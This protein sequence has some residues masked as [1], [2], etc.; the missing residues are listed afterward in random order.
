MLIFL[1]ISLTFSI[2]VAGFFVSKS[3]FL[4]SRVRDLEDS[5]DILKQQLEKINFERINFMN[6]YSIEKEKYNDIEKQSNKLTLELI[7]RNKQIIER[8]FEEKNKINNENIG[9]LT[10]KLFC[11]FK[12]IIEKVSN[13]EEKGKD[14]EKIVDNL[15]NSLL[16]PHKAGHTSEITLENILSNSGLVKKNSTSDV[17]DYIVQPCIKIDDLNLR[18]DAIVFL[19][20]NNYL[21]IDSKT[22]SHFVEL[23]NAVD[24]SDVFKEKEIKQKIKDRINKHLS[25]LISKNY[26]QALLDFLRENQN[27]NVE[28][29][30]LTV[31]FVQT[32]GVLSKIREIDCDIENRARQMEIPIASPLGLINLLNISKFTIQKEIQDKNLEKLKNELFILMDNLATVFERTE[33]IGKKLY[34]AVGSYNEL[35]TTFNSNLLA[36]IKNIAKLGT[37]GKKDLPNRL[38]KFELTKDIIDGEIEVINNSSELIN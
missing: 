27:S 5:E 7:E 14:V 28:P 21:I 10:E 18:P 32:E 26:K 34:E 2:S 16:T 25:D 19:P 17:G 13:I 15:Q 1:V 22:S 20:N 3:I 35:A 31:M 33:K 36:R 8:G 12:K 23:Q 37:K 38:V 24:V 29:T 30:I 9:N 6:L 4:K 11:D